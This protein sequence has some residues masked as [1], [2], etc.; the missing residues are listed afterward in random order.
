MLLH[1]MLL[2]TNTPNLLLQVHIGSGSALHRPMLS[3][4]NTVNAVRW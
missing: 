3:P 4:S 2:D 1:T